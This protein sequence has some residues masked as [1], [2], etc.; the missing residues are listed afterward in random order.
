[1]SLDYGREN[2][3]VAKKELENIL[4]KLNKPIKFWEEQMFPK[5][6]TFFYGCLLPEIV[7]P[8]YPGRP[9]RN[10]QYIIDA[11]SSTAKKK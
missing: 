4:N 2:E 9:I 6:Q 5:L 10:P 3:V 8:R 11:Q 1:M 7:D